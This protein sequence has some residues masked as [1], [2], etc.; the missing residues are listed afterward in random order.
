MERITGNRF[1]WLQLV[2]IPALAGSLLI[3][4]SPV[5]AHEERSASAMGEP[6]FHCVAIDKEGRTDPRE[7]ARVAARLQHVAADGPVQVLV[8]V[9]GFQTPTA[10]ADEDYQ[11]AAA[12]FGKIGSRLGM[13]TFLVGVHWDSGSDALGKWLPKAVGSRIT[14]LLGLK[15]AVKNPYLE[16][17]EYARL[18]GRTGLRSILFSL[19]DALPETPVH[20]FAH[21]LGAQVVVSGLAPEASVDKPTDEITERGRALQ[22]GIVTLAGADV[23]YDAFDRD[24]KHN[25]QRALGQAQVWWITVPEKK[26]ADGMLELRRGAGRGHALGNR[27]LKLSKHDVDRLLRRRGL[28]IDMGDVPV[29]HGFADYCSPRRVEALARSYSYLADPKSAAG[30]V[31]TLA[32]LDQ[33]LTSEPSAL[34]VAD[35]EPCSHRLYKTWR[36]NRPVSK[37]P[38]IAV[39]NTGAG[40]VTDAPAGS[41]DVMQVSR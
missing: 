8:M 7:L 36:L 18:V 35:T 21:S 31:S 14:S 9:H 1:S 15:K 37:Y 22:L 28:V 13:R 25:F 19:Q 39:S 16:K 32:A 2:G 30:S 40:A 17:V 23:D 12:Q 20:V 27:G 10:S 38:A 29:K 41:T 33:V 3:G 24:R 4:A 11:A 5:S 34:R 26:T 6:G